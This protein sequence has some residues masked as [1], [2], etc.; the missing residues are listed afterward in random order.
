MQIEKKN[1][2]EFHKKYTDKLI[3]IIVPV[4]KV[5][6]YIEECMESLVNQTIHNIEI[7]LIDNGNKDRASDIIKEYASNDARIRIIKLEE[8]QGM[9]KARNIGLAAATGE[10]IAFVDSDDLCD[11]TMFEKLY[12]QAKKF[13][14]DVVTCNVLRFSDDWRKGT[15][16][17]PESWYTGTNSATPITGCPEQF[18]E[19]AAW[20][21][22]SKRSYIEQLDYRFTEGSVFCED[23]PACTQLFLNANRI[24]IVN[25]TLYFYRNRQGSLSNHMDRK[26]IDCFVWAMQKQDELI[27]KSD[28]SDELTLY[29]IINARFLLANHIMTKIPRKDYRYFFDSLGYVFS[30]KDIPFIEGYTENFAL[31]KKII[32]IIK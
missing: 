31:A 16:H 19:M 14:A 17:H 20:A 8:N 30:K 2:I 11:I 18:M 7:I 15:D 10:Y 21:K 32:K 23:V 28:F 1:T 6:N 4:Y 26:H 27:K 24:A 5:E 13:D 22:I 3:S 9:P 25:E 29:Y 12:K